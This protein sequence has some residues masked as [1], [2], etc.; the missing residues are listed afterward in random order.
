MTEEQK[1]ATEPTPDTVESG[2][3]G[4]SPDN[5]LNMGDQPVGWQPP[6]EVPADA[7]TLSAGPVDEV[8]TGAPEGSAQFAGDNAPDDDDEEEAD[9][10]E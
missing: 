4:Q 9:A 7:A 10:A 6:P 2:S 8:I 3:A 1:D 5:P